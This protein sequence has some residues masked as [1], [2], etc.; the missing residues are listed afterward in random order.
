MALLA[1]LSGRQQVACNVGTFIPDY[2]APHPRIYAP[3]DRNP[4]TDSYDGSLQ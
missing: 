3:S 2:T 4:C 1:P